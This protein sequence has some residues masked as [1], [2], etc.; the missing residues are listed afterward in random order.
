MEMV[1]GSLTGDRPKSTLLPDT[2]AAGSVC[3]DRDERV[4]VVDGRD[5]AMGNPDT[6]KFVESHPRRA[7]AYVNCR[8]RSVTLLRGV[9]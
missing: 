3:S 4:G 8:G 6:E 1:S 2:A 7:P 5:L 9:L